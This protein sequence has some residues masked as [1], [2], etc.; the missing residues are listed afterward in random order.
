MAGM[1]NRALILVC[2][3]ITCHC[4]NQPGRISRQEYKRI[5]EGFA[6]PHDTNRLWC[7]YYWI[8]DDISKEGI[9]KD[10][11]AMK[12]FGVGSQL[13]Q[14]TG[15]RHTLELARTRWPDCTGA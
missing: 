7:Y 10:L 1:F 12:E 2:V 4:C 13:A 15:V 14:A 6:S 5:Q 8:G 3:I 9:T 11:E